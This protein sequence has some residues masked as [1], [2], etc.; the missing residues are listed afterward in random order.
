[1]K[2]AYSYVLQFIRYRVNNVNFDSEGFQFDMKIRG[3]TYYV[4]FKR[5]KVASRSK[6]AT[7]SAVPVNSGMETEDDQ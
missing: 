4:T 1:M 7:A 3:D 5:I 2:S 6:T